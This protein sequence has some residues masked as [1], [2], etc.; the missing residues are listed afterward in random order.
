MQTLD[1]MDDVEEDDNGL[2][3]RQLLLL[4]DVV[5]QVDETSVLVAEVVGHQTVQHQTQPL[6]QSTRQLHLATAVDSLL[7]SVVLGVTKG[8]FAGDVKII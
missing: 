2:L 4:D 5:L 1:D 7:L 3:L 8:D 6:S